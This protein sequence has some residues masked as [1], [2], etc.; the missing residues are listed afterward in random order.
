MVDRDCELRPQESYIAI[1]IFRS[2]GLRIR[3]R[4]TLRS[5]GQ[6]HQD[7]VLTGVVI[8]DPSPRRS[9]ISVS[10]IEDET[11]PPIN[12]RNRAMEC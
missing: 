7:V 8:L 4:D 11:K 1:S 5:S 2:I 3:V 9:T 12:P 6:L 10:H